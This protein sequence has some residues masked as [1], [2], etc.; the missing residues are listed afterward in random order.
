MKQESLLDYHLYTLPRSTT[1]AEGSD[2]A[3]SADVRESYLPVTK[4]FLLSGADYYYFSQ[5]AD[6]DQ[7]SKVGVIF[8]FQNSGKG[9]GLP[10]PKGIVRVYKKDSQGHGRNSWARIRSTIRRGMDLCA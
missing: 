8:E 4:Q 5:S 9:L 10:L 7:I 1:L 6:L 2:Q 3:G